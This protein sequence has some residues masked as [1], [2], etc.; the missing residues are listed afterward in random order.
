M[1]KPTTAERGTNLQQRLT[2][3]MNQATH[4]DSSP[5]SFKNDPH[6][7][8]EKLRPSNTLNHQLNTAPYV[9]EALKTIDFKIHC[10][11]DDGVNVPNL[12]GI[13]SYIHNELN[14]P[15]KFPRPLVVPLGLSEVRTNYNF[16]FVNDRSPTYM[17]D[18]LCYWLYFIKSVTPNVEYIIKLF[19]GKDDYP[20]EPYAPKRATWTRAEEKLKTL[21]E[22]IRNDE[23]MGV[24]F[25]SGVQS[26][27]CF[28]FA[29]KIARVRDHLSH[30]YIKKTALHE[31]GHALLKTNFDDH[32]WGTVMETYTGGMGDPE[33]P[34]D[35]EQ[36]Q[37]ILQCLKNRLT[38][39]YIGQ[40]DFI[41]NTYQQ[42]P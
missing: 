39:Y 32:K 9:S 40:L 24:T 27:I 23:T 25:P 30:K 2:G 21:R 6:S 31:L 15:S 16:M 35:K 28:V 8:N 33:Y 14:N 29:N 18:V 3:V 38:E 36:R 13:Q 26:A 7:I 5:R 12:G 17:Y 19:Y 34:F 20:V 1:A 11:V 22:F 37:E 10:Y 4:T 42:N 41:T